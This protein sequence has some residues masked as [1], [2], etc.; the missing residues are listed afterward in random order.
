MFPIAYQS[1]GAVTPARASPST[2]RARPGWNVS[3]SWNAAAASPGRPARSSISASCS[4]ARNTGPVHGSTVVARSRSA[5]RRIVSRASLT[6]PR[7][8]AAQALAESPASPLPSRVPA[9]AVAD[10]E[11]PQRA[12]PTARASRMSSRP[13][14]VAPLS[15]RRP[16]PGNLRHRAPLAPRSP[17]GRRR[18]E[19]FRGASGIRR[20]FEPRWRLLHRFVRLGGR[21]RT[22]RRAHVTRRRSRRRDG[23]RR[24]TA[25]WPKSLPPT[26]R[27]AR[28]GARADGAD[29][30]RRRA[31][32]RVPPRRARRDR[33][34]PDDPRREANNAGGPPRWP[35][36]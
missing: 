7:A 20:R 34:M 23:Q 31:A 24:P 17:R 19:A 1:P 13:W 26:S 36:P 21:R 6:R 2:A 30:R 3:T 28:R 33:R 15:S 16:P 9:A 4:R 29:T 14:P 8:N 5:A 35:G 32:R 10:G 27:A 12:A 11:S 25:G 22:A 18:F